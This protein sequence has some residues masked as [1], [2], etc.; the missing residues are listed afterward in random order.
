MKP[1][2]PKAIHLKDYQAPAYLVENIYLTFELGATTTVTSLLNIKAELNTA[3]QPLVL[4]G[5]DLELVSISIN[6]KPLST[7]D[8]TVSDE[9]LTITKVPDAFSLEIITKIKPDENTSLDGLYQSSGNFCTQCEAEGF[10]KITYFLDRPD[11]MTS[12]TVKVIADKSNYPV[13]L[14]NGNL[15]EEGKLNDGLHFAVWHDPHR[16]PCYLFALVAGKLK[17]IEDHFVTQSGKQVL[18]RVYVEPQN[19]KKCEHAMQSLIKSMKWDEETFGLEYDLD[20]YMIVAVDDFNMGAMENKGLNVFNSQYVLAQPDTATDQDYENIEG[21][22]GHEYFHNWT[23]NRVTCRDWFQ[24]SLKEGLTVFRDQEFSSEMGSR[25]VKRIDDVKVLRTRQF[26]EDAGPMAHP[27]RPESYIE[28]SNF[29]TVTVYNKG[30]E[31]IRMIHTLLG[32]QGFRRGMDLYFQRHDGQ[33]V[34]TE[35]FVSAMADANKVNLDHFQRWYQQAGTPVVDIQNKY[36]A[37]Q[38]KLTVT[39]QQSCP[40]TPK[41]NKKQPFHIPLAFGLLGKNGQALDIKS[42][43]NQLI[44]R[45]GNTI[46]E[47]TKQNQTF[48]FLEVNEKPVLSVFRGYSAPIQLKHIPSDDDLYLL[49]EHDSDSF[50]RWESGQQLAIK[51]LLKMIQQIK[52]KQ[53]FEQPDRYIHAV[54]KILEN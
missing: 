3:Q 27:I 51:T 39:L 25:A 41:Q 15:I 42:K 37:D 54:K 43:D 52:Q 13:L 9:Q 1:D 46:L 38:K 29:Y 31:V 2:Q 30:A 21:V 33:A 5:I 16:K 14:S 45:D 40:P 18:L 47:L 49:M 53:A 32:K 26:Q 22:I 20:R 11:V 48:E 6:Q 17:Y 24:L 7:N 34:T 28:I 10:R 19:I 44:Q 4:D 12:F 50:N 23:G 8:Y 35:D 36:D